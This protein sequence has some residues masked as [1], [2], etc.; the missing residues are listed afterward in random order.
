MG[1]TIT[2]ERI[3]GA[4]TDVYLPFRAGDEQIP[5][6]LNALCN[7]VAEEWEVRKSKRNKNTP[8]ANMIINWLRPICVDILTYCDDRR[9]LGLLE[10][11]T[12]QHKRYVYVNEP[13]YRAMRGIFSGRTGF[14]LADCNR[15]SEYIRFALRHYQSGSEVNDFFNSIEGFDDL[16]D[17]DEL[18]PG[19]EGMIIDRRRFPFDL[20]GIRGTYPKY[21]DSACRSHSVKFV[22]EYAQSS[23][24]NEITKPKT[25]RASE[26]GA[27]A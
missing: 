8:K 19:Y 25:K 16:T 15:Y 11:R 12:R 2:V 5:T 24:W 27:S 20:G 1:I 10:D 17:P 6:A 7:L 14:T 23:D 4:A 22:T 26:D 9:C 18:I 13:V 3:R 21:I